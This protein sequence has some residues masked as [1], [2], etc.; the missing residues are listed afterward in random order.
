MMPLNQLFS[1][2]TRVALP[3][4]SKL[5]DDWPRFNAFVQRA[6]MV[7]SYAAVAVFACAFGAAGPLVEVALGPQWTSAAPIFSILVIGGCFQAVSYVAYWI[8]LAKGLT[9]SHLRYSLI[10]RS[11]LVVAVIIGSLWDVE[12]IA[13][14]YAAGLVLGWPLS[15]WW[16]SRVSDVAVKPLFV[17]G[18]KIV[19][20]G[21]LP[22]GLGLACQGLM[23]DYGP[24]LTLIASATVSVLG[25]AAISM[26]IPAYRRDFKV[27]LAT[28][29]LLKKS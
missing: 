1:P 3:A 7:L 17:G 27:I 14:G 12:G 19:T 8:F 25:L 11:A 16:L 24:L 13:I 21:L 20:W 10:S 23:A 29:R 22:A 4:L 15:L 28:T 6:Q 18:L 9:G 2:M 5:Q 26:A